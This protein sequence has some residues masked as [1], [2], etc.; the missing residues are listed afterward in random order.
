MRVA[1]ERSQGLQERKEIGALAVRER[2]ESVARV[3]RLTAVSAH[4]TVERNFTAVVQVERLP[5]EA[6]ER[7][8][9]E[10][11]LERS[12]LWDAVTGTDVVEQQVREESDLAARDGR[13]AIARRVRLTVARGAADAAERGE[14]CLVLGGWFWRRGKAHEVRERRDRAGR[15]FWVGHVVHQ[16]EKRGVPAGGDLIGE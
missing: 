3:G 1:I 7:R 2:H 14:A 4:R 11:V 8:R 9:P 16:R 12:R 5:A 15:R 10:L 13:R 6:P